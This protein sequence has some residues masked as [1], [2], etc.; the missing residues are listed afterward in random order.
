MLRGAVSTGFALA[1]ITLWTLLLGAFCVLIRLGESAPLV[2]PA[3]SAE[4]IAPWCLVAP[5]APPT[6]ERLDVSQQP[7]SGDATDCLG[8][9][10]LAPYG[11]PTTR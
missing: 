1:T 5:S 4:G 7:E 3:A 11:A 10:L 9:F 8:R 6:E 2:V